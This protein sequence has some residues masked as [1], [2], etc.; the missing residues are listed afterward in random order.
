MTNFAP[1][2][3][4]GILQQL[5]DAGQLGTYQ[6]LIAPIVLERPDAYKAFF[7]E[8]DDQF[9]LMDNGV[10]EL[11]YALSAVQLY[12][13]V[14]LVGAQLVVMPDTIDDM[15]M[16]V[17]QV[18]FSLGEYRKLDQATDTMGVVQGLDFEECLSCANHLVEAGV[19]WLGVPRGLTPNL[20]SRVRLVKTLGDTFRKPMHVLGFSEDLVDDVMSAI[21][22]PLVQGMDAATPVWLSF[23]QKSET[24][25]W[26]RTLPW[27]PPTVANF[28][29]RPADF[30]QTNHVE[31]IAPIVFNIDRVRGWLRDSNVVPD[32]LINEERPADLAGQSMPS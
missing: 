24:G 1:V 17:K 8:H 16:T 11:G 30:W 27:A 19:D 3:P 14:Q 15:K 23:P 6:L 21:A 28:G 31:P 20:G 2:A 26:V 25:P 5:A 32:A 9:I 18:R 7:A 13:A 10:I 29:R 22:H 12:K 4:L